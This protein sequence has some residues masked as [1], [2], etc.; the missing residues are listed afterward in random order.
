MMLLFA[1]FLR[2]IPVGDS[3]RRINPSLVLFWLVV[4]SCGLMTHRAV[5]GKLC[6]L[7][8]DLRCNT[9]QGCTN[10][11]PRVIVL[12]SQALHTVFP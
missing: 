4:A 5:G 6:C 9:R 3:R 12:D 10:K 1:L 8:L 2:V 7:G 11:N